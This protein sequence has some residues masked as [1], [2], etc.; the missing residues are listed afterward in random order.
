MPIKSIH[1][2]SMFP[3]VAFIIEIMVNVSDFDFLWLSCQFT[4]SE[5]S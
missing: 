1:S 4:P 3:F 5:A 2:A